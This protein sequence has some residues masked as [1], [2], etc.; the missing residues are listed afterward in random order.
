MEAIYRIIDELIEYAKAN[1]GLDPFDERYVRNDIINILNIT[2]YI[3]QDNIINNNLDDILNELKKEGIN[4]K[5]FA[6][7]EFEAISDSIMGLLSYRPGVV[8]H[9]FKTSDNGMK[10][11]YD[12]SVKNNYVKKSL[13]DK[14][15]RFESHGLIVTINKAKPE[16]KNPKEAAKQTKIGG[17]PSCTICREN[18]GFYGRCKRTLRTVDIQMNGNPWF[19]QFSPYGYFNEHGIAVNK[20]HTPM[21]VNRNTF[22]NLLDFVTQYPNY[23][24]GC[25][26]ALPRIGG[27]VLAH[28]HYQGGS[29]VLPLHKA[30]VYKYI[31]TK[32]TSLRVG[33]L[34]WPGNVIRISGSNIEDIVDCSCDIMNSWNGYEDISKDIVNKDING[35]HNAISPTAIKTK[36]GYEMNI[37][38]RNN[39]TNDKYPDGVFHAHPI[40]HSIKKESIGLIEAQ[41]LFILPA[42]LDNELSR[43]IDCVKNKELSNDLLEFKLVYDK[44]IER[45]DRFNS[46][47]EALK[48]VLGEICYSILENTAVFKE[49]SDLIDFTKGCFK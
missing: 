45:L 28:D 10:W 18:E 4:N 2:N 43:V 42:R 6:E 13:L 36:D 41:G 14:N 35:N 30:N 31:D 1:L 29:E 8:N 23:F 20:Y 12:Y 39:Y 33:V 24:I 37:I 38:L 47:D 34:D 9:L 3:K 26:A 46:I 7:Y 48:D 27:S 21:H 49:K 19:W 32:Y 17:Y 22:Y 16:F 5:L 40:Y 44:I 15:P 25:N 11:L